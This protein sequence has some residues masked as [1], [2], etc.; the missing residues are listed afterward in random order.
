M[1]RAM[2]SFSRVPD[3]MSRIGLLNEKP[4]HASLKQWYAQPGDRFEVPVDGF[5]IDIVR[6]DVLLEIQ[7]RHFGAIKSKLATLVSSHRVRLIHPIACEKW[8]VQSPTN[9][10][11]FGTRRKSPKRGRVEDLFRELV[12]IPRLLSHQNFSLEVLLTREEETRRFD[13]RR[14]RTRG[15]V[16]EERRLLD[17]VDR[18]VFDGPASWLALL[19]GFSEPFTSRELAQAIGVRIDLAQKIIYSLR[20]AGFVQ[21][22]GKQGRAPLYNAGEPRATNHEP[23][24]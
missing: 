16:I 4:L 1:L 12:A 17:V 10:H 9:G 22:I 14:W 6:D 20:E 5:V 11:G 24:T 8:I 23:R 13:R 21:A 2:V 15:W 3:S 18:R 19:P 7:T